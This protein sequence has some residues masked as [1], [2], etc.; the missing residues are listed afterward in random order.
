MDPQ[1]LANMKRQ[2]GL[3]ILGDT[4]AENATMAVLVLQGRLFHLK[5]TVELSDEAWKPET[6]LCGGPFSV[7]TVPAILDKCRHADTLERQADFWRGIANKC[8][9]AICFFRDMMLQMGNTEPA[10]LAQDVMDELA[11]AEKELAAS[12]EVPR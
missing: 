7:Q 8:R 1:D 11:E 4:R 5:P 3:Y 2:D 12:Q 6:Y 10:K 9:P